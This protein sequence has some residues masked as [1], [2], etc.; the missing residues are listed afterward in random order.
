MN[1]SCFPL[2]I[3]SSADFLALIFLASDKS[4]SFTSSSFVLV[5]SRYS[6]ATF[7]V[8]S[9]I[10]RSK[11][12]FIQLPEDNSSR[13]SGSAFYKNSLTRTVSSVESFSIKEYRVFK[14]S[15]PSFA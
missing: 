14:N 3:S 1:I 15:S 10:Q 2:S 11:F 8:G 12:L 4:F 9:P 7:F 13:I 5:L 6:Q